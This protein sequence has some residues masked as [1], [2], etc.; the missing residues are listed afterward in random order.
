MKKTLFT[1]TAF[2]ISIALLSQSE[3]LLHWDFEKAEGLYV[4][5]SITGIGDSIGGNYKLIETGYSGKAYKPD[6]FTACIHVNSAQEIKLEGSFSVE[7][8]LTQAA[9]PWNWVPVIACIQEGRQRQEGTRGFY[10]AVGPRG[11]LGMEL[12]I[13]GELYRCITDDYTL[14]LYEWK[15][16]VAVYTES[17]G[18]QLFIDGRPAGYAA[19]NKK[20]IL[21]SNHKTRIGMNFSTVKPSDIHRQF[22]TLPYWFSFDGAIDELKVYDYALDVN[23]LKA[24]FILSGK[25]APFP[26]REMPEVKKIDRFGA[27]YTK[28][29]YYEEWDELWPV[30]DHPDII[31]N[32]ENSGIRLVFWRGTRY[33]PAWISEDDFWMADQSVEAWN[34]TEGCYEH[35]Q[36]RHC[37][38]S[39]VRILE[40]TPARVLVHW[41]YAPVSVYDLTW[42]VNEK[43]GW[44]CWID[45]YYYIYPDG[46][47]IRHVEWKTGTLGHP[48]Q[49]QESIPLAGPGQLRGDIMDNPWLTVSNQEGDSQVYEYVKDPQASQKKEPDNPNIQKHNFKSDF[50]PFIIFET[51]NRM[52]YLGDRNIENLQKPGSC[53]HWPV[54]QAYCDGRTG[55]APD[56]PT[57]F[58]GFP[59]SSPVIT[60]K[61]GRSWWNG[62]YG[63]TDKPVDYL[64]SLS[65]SWNSSPEADLLTSGYS[66]P[67]YSRTERAYK[68][69]RLSGNEPL[70]IRFKAD[71]N[72]PLV[73][74]VIIIE[75]PGMLEG[76][77]MINGKEITDDY[78]K[79]FV[80]T[81]D[82][83][84]LII[85]LFSE[86]NRPSEIKVF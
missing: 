80:S 2:L 43:T 8:W 56:R 19:V 48:R 11:Q 1:T 86:F 46:S 74:P 16:V 81:L 71:K 32:F 7:A 47:A 66:T 35:M 37:K 40:N 76:N 9:Y 57:S 30:A 72:Q 14:P 77:V 42:N 5:E 21:P 75:N 28:L 39:H 51:G 44:E 33:S 70:E 63:M 29:R 64:V 24:D 52:N 25:K 3:P 85:F 59:I 36:D 4:Y 49:F 10:F 69:E 67:L 53:N 60:E 45:E 61:N 20:F 12:Y 6:G 50:D 82:S 15:H 79:G 26:E 17:R 83:D 68:V 31:V 73:N 27:S 13:E 78:R 84:R 34:N 54:G 65:R 55:I 41:R 18:I 58:L 62:L 22:G 38:Y 23:R